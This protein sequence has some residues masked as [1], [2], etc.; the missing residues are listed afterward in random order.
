[1]KHEY[2]EGFQNLINLLKTLPGVGRRTAERMAFSMLKWPPEKLAEFGTAICELRR[3]TTSCPECG[4]LSSSGSLCSI[5]AS[6][7]RDK[8]MIC[9]VEE[10][11]QIYNIEQ[12]GLFKGVYHVIGGKLSPLEGKGIGDLNIKALLKRIEIQNVKEVIIAFSSDVEGQA[13]S[14]YIAE[15]LKKK[16]VH[17]TRLAQGLPAGSDISYAD[18]ATIAAALHGRRPL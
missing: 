13:T 10:S 16:N 8:T 4:N 15:E 11:V 14:I 6:S 5:C 3:S 9:A 17:V 12:S 1:M 18:S 7:S 2:P